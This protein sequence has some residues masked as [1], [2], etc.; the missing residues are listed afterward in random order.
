MNKRTIL[1]LMGLALSEIFTLQAQVQKHPEIGVDIGDQMP[2][3]SISKMLNSSKKTGSTVDYHNKLLI[4]DFWNTGCGSCVEALPKMQALQKQFGSR[5]AILP[6]TYEKE[7]YISTFLKNNKYTKGLKLPVVVDD[8][9]FKSMFKHIYVPHEVWVYKGKV[10][11]ATLAEY[12]DAGNIKRVLNGELVNWPIKND[13]Y[14]FNP[15]VPLFAIDSQQI[16]S[17]TPLTYAAISDFREKFSSVVLMGRSGIVRDTLK[18]TV[19][20]YLLNQS[21]FGAYAST[22]Q[23]AGRGKMRV[24][25]YPVLQDNQV[26]WEVDD[27]S[28]FVYEKGDYYQQEWLRKNGICFESQYPDTGQSDVAVYSSVITDLDRLLGLHVSWEKRKEK[29][30]LLVKDK[31]AII[32]KVKP[33]MKN[34]KCSLSKLV[35]NL[36][37]QR[38]N[39]YV[40]DESGDQSAEVLLDSA[41]L[42][43]VQVAKRG[44][45]GSGYKLEQKER[46]V[47]CLIFA[48]VDGTHLTDGDMQRE[49]K[50][51]KEEAAN[52]AK[53]ILTEE[54]K[55][56][57]EEN[58]KK[59]GVKVTSSGLQYKIL[60]VGNGPRL[61]SKNKVRVHYEGRLVNGKIFDSSY[62]RGR[63]SDIDIDKV[64]PGWKEALQLMQLGAKWELFIPAELG[65]GT[66]TARGTIPSNST[67]IFT[68]EFL[69]I[70]P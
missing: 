14:T 17:S 27:R 31:G 25:P 41:A 34:E 28:K 6:V 4:I 55:E 52:Q 19:R 11:G 5:I 2:I 46:E 62:G 30:L 53:E 37:R 50:L 58:M 68:I 38:G 44:L 12:V 16:A 54:N 1:I 20:C 32:T 10:I 65:Y 22:W 21:V 51:R 42:S 43:N 36:N 9:M 18:K 70:L 8:T 47:D 45:Q 3:F 49:A 67:L 39:P 23:K 29:V 57:L 40:F 63:P 7:A 33:G 15:R 59:Q 56:F 64:I 60:K 66:H 69:K 24:T 13:F 48:E 26:R 61:I 35:Y